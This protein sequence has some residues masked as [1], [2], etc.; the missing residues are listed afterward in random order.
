MT[1]PYVGRCLGSDGP[2]LEGSRV[3]TEGVETG[4]CSACSGRFELE[5]G[6]LVPHETAHEDERESV[7]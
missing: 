1:V 6:R 7:T 2:P 5:D 3:V 4:L